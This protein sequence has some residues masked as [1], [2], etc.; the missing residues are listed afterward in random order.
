M[1]SCN[2]SILRANI[3]FVFF[4]LFSLIAETANAQN[5]DFGKLEMRSHAY[6]VVI[7]MQIE[8][9]FGVN[10][11]DQ[12]ERYLGTIVTEDGLV[13]FDGTD[14]ASD[15]I[16]SSFSGL[17][18]KTTPTK[19]E[20]T[21]LDGIS[22][23]GELLGF[24]RFTKVGFIKIIAEENVTF[25]PVKFNKH[26]EFEIGEWLA[27]FMLMPE[28]VTPPLSADIGMVSNLV[29]SPEPFPLTVGF[30]SLQLASV[31]F[32][33]S[34]E[35]VGILG[36]L[37]DPSSGS[38]DGGAMMGSFGSGG[39]PMLGV[40]TGE[41]I[42]ELLAS[43]PTEGEIERGWLGISLQALTQDIAEFWQLDLAG[44]IIVNEIIRNSPAEK[45][46]LKVGDIIYEVN[47]QLVE[48]DREEKVAVF[49]RM[50]AN[51]GPEAA[52][53]LEVLRLNQGSSDTTKIL[54]NL[55]KAPISPTEAP[56]FKEEVLELTVRDLV[57]ADYMIY[58]LDSE[59]FKGVVVSGLTLGGPASIGGLLIGDVIQRIGPAEIESVDDAKK[60]L[61][62][63]S[64]EQPREVIF[65][66]WRRNQ[67]M[68]VNVKPA[69]N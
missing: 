25:S 55:E 68:F 54:I 16:F 56:D 4:I 19:I 44:G 34:H 5:F 64:I 66:I 28:F 43:P 42:E 18:V 48:V 40:I 46:G 31:L 24:D 49:Q 57:F 69:W 11:S 33:E 60:V 23:D 8:V 2:R 15:N 61:S 17:T 59:N 39:I 10:T 12:E 62:E 21:T 65:F 51:F 7:D 38:A 13:I 3:L 63:I 67:T 9:S 22:Y 47:G 14:I 32:N 45:G 20:I 1:K 30:N 53:E 52:V 27:L 36:T 41:R 6:I 35:P 29:E 26:H 50:I 58:N 37:M